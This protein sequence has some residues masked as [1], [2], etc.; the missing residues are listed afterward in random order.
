MITC[1]PD[2]F[3][4]IIVK[5]K[6]ENKKTG[7]IKSK[8]LIKIGGNAANFS[9]ALSKLGLKNNLIAC[10]GKLSYIIAK[11]ELKKLKINFYPVF[12]KNNITVSIEKEDRIMFTDSRGI[13]I[14]KIS[15]YLDIIKKSEYI[16]F[17]NWNNNKKSNELLKWIIENSNAKIYLDIGDPSVNR[18]NLPNLIKILKEG[19]IWTLSLNEHELSYLCNFLGINGEDY[20]ELSKNLFKEIK[21]K[22]LDIHSPDF[23]YSL[24]SDTY[25]KIEKIKPKILTGAGDVWN[26]ANFFGYYKKFSNIERLKFANEI[27]KKYILGIF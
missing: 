25:I 26:A 5:S 19:K 8:I 27:A 24:P 3:L 12:T 22:N 14:S 18:K 21:V 2:L 11:K 6:K 20:I 4:D 10:C 23:V 16:F 15:K 13:Q 7:N 17:G 9:I 1:L